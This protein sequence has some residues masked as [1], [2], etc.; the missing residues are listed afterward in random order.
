M[1]YNWNINYI[2]CLE[3]WLNLSQGAVMDLLTHLSSW[4]E[5]KEIDWEIFFYLSTSKMIEELPIISE[6]RGTFLKIIQTLKEKE[7][8]NHKL[9]QNRSWYNLTEKWKSFISQVF[10]EKYEKEGVEN[11]THSTESV[12]KITHKCVK[13]YTPGVEKITHYNNTS[14]N[15]TSNNKISKDILYE[16]KEKSFLEIF[17]EKILKNE[18]FLEKIKNKFSLENESLKSSAENFLIYWTEKNENWKKE[19]WE[20]QKTFDIQKRFFMRLSNEK[21][22]NK[23]KNFQNRTWYVDIDF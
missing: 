2:K 22:W 12:E 5:W 6:N 10:D 21:K 16:K 8:I 14:N 4:A 20:K 13:N 3:F 1:K 7:L 19:K 9:Y 18:E 11:F 17:E 23:N 15:N